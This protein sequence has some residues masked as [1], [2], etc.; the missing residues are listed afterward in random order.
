MG[1]VV[2]W[3][4]SGVAAIFVVRWRVPGGGRAGAFG[5]PP[6]PCLSAQDLFDRPV[7]S[8]HLVASNF[9]T[10]VSSLLRMTRPE[11]A[12]GLRQVAFEVLFRH[13]TQPS[14]FIARCCPGPLV[15]GGGG[16][17]G[18]ERVDWGVHRGRGSSV[19]DDP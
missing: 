18:M 11:F 1:P 16:G 12:P 9:D 2:R 4:S 8:A 7:L 19:P 14:H 17:G 3:T 10:F 6:L 5:P 15:R 13:A